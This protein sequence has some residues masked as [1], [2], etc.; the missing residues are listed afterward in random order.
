MEGT[1]YKTDR[2]GTKYYH[3]NG[4]CP[5]CGGTG[6][7]PQY[8]FNEG[9]LCFTCNGSGFKRIT[10]K[11]YT[12]EYEAKLNAKKNAKRIAQADETNK[13]FL[14]KYNF[15]EDGKIYVVLGNTYEIK[16]QLKAEGAR[17]SQEFGWSFNENKP[18]T[19]EINIDEVANKNDYNEYC[20]KEWYEIK[21][22]IKNKISELTGT[23]QLSG[24][25]YNELLVTY[26]KEHNLKGIRKRMTT[27]KLVEI[28]KNANLS[29]P[30][31]TVSI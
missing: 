2:N 5:A 21:E 4:I 9:G 25:E 14:R 17:Y 22:I 13:F 31:R 6:Y 16:E 1:L 19:I 12:P 10:W 24:L 18:N 26:A 3:N 8:H 7:L 27:A 11:K 23:R 15:N 20:L 30:E 28:I 29:V